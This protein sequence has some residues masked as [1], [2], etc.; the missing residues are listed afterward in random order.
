MRKVIILALCLVSIGIGMITPAA[1]DAASN[2]ELEE[3]IKKIEAQVESKSSGGWPEWT[4]RITI[5]GVIEAE[6]GFV[7][8]DYADPGTADTDESDIVLATVE[9]GVDAQIHKHVSGH[10]L[11]LFEED[12]NDDNIAVDEGF[13]A[14]DGADVVPVYLNAGKFY[15]P[16]GNFESHMISDPVTLE[17]AETNESAVQVGF[18]NDW[19]DASISVFNGDVDEAGDDSVI[20][21]YVGSVALT[22]PEGAIPNLG[23]SAGVSYISN[24][25]DSDALID[26]LAVTNS[27]IDYVPA[28]GAFIHVAFKEMAFLKAE[29]IGALDNFQAGEFTAIDGGRAIEPSAWNIELACAPVENLEVAVRYAQTD[30]IF[31]GIDDAGAFPESQYGLTVAYGL[32]NSTTVALEYLKND[33]ENDDEASV[34]TAQVAIEF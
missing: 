32:F 24:I 22:V 12:E 23:L 6:A 9:L 14:L 4:D 19:L 31:G 10:I 7:N 34:V 20:D 3:R 13:I 21:S 17:L 28:F 2:A 16:F 5:S 8:N 11:F 26:E 29:Y 33:Y 30:D 25:A 15:V 27:V 18:A 1:A